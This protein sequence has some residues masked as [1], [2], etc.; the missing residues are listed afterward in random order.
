MDSVSETSMEYF[1]RRIAVNESFD[2]IRNRLLWNASKV[3]QVFEIND[4]E[5]YVSKNG[6]RKNGVWTP[7]VD[8]ERGL[9][10]TFNPNILDN[11]SIPIM[12]HGFNGQINPARIHIEFDVRLS[13]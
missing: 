12:Y 10:F 7:I 1:A 4:K 8:S 9:C 13:F 2:T 5:I 11:V 6:I 3:I